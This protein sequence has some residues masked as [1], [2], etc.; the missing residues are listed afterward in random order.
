MRDIVDTTDLKES[1]LNNYSSLLAKQPE[2]LPELRKVKENALSVL[3]AN[4]FPT[5]ANEEWKYT[6]LSGILKK[7]FSFLEK[8][9]VT[10]QELEQFKFEGLE[11]NTFVFVNGKF[12]KALSSIIDQQDLLEV[13]SFS[14]FSA[15]TSDYFVK[16]AESAIDSFSSLNLAFPEDAAFIRVPKGKSPKFPLVFYYIND[17]RT[18]AIFTQPRLTLKSEEN[19]SV[20]VVEYHVSLG[21]KESFTNAYSEFL[22]DLNSRVDYYK[23]QQEGEESYHVGTTD[24][25][26]LAKSTFFATTITLD[27]SLIRNNINVCLKA[28]HVESHLYGLYLADGKRHIDNHTLVDHAAPNCYSNEL[29]KGVLAGKS[30][31]VFNGKILVREDAQKTNAFQSNKN[32]LLSPDATMNTKPQL[33]IFADDV[34]CSHGATV[35]QLSEEPLFYLRSRGLS[36]KK[37]KALLTLAFAHDIIEHVKIP[38]LKELLKSLIEEN[39]NKE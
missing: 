16:K 2:T 14:E 6:N 27:G 37:A 11:A 7:E 8:G 36:E 10:A 19:S 1:L 20:Q 35:G 30:T 33:E 9:T 12:N 28:P 26:H 34:K 23:I 17:R 22:L 4:G 24:V 31:G 25:Q 39:L 3:A 32:I 15:E 5:T 38:V 21:S 29:Y 18:E 13:N